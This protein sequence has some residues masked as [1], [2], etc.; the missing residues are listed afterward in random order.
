[1]STN[2]ELCFFC[3]EKKRNE[4]ECGEISSYSK[5]ERQLKKFIGIDP[6]Y[7]EIGRLDDGTGIAKTLETHN[8]VYHKKCY[9]KIGQKEYNRLLARVGKKTCSEANSSSSTVIPHKRTETELGTE[10]WIFCGERDST[11]D[12]CAAE[13]FHF[14]SST[15]NQHV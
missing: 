5:I 8:T 13:E 11:E 4:K 3:Q 9:D 15:N 6:T 14:G 2:W 7:T 10:F 1:M 12:V